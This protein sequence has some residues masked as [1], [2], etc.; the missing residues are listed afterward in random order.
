MHLIS[1]Q[2]SERA[3][4]DSGKIIS[5][6]GRTHVAWQDVTRQGYFNRVRT[7]DHATG[8]WSDPITLDRGVDNHARAVLCIDQD[9][10]LHAILGG[11]G[12]PVRWCHAL[13]YN[14]VS[15][16]SEPQPLGLGTYPVF[17]CGPDGTLYLTLRGNGQQRQD[18]GVDLYRRPPGGEWSCQRLVTL[19]EEYGQVYAAYHMQ[20]DAGPDG[21]LHAIIDF[22]EGED[23]H[24]RG[25]H[26]AT[27]YC[28]SN[29]GG[30]TWTRADGTP[31]TLPAR[32]EDLDILAQ[33]TR[34][35]HE[36]LPQ[37]DI[38][39]GGLI[40]DTTGQPFA[41]YID[42]DHGPGHCLLVTL[43]GSTLRQTPLQD[44]WECLYPDMRA[45]ECNLVRRQDDALCLLVTLAPFDNEWLDGKPTRA[46]RM[47]ERDDFRLIWLFSA[48]GGKTFEV[49]P[50]LEAGQSYN[51]PS[52]EKAVGPNAVPADRMPAV[53]YFDGSREYPGGGDYYAGDR[54]VD[55][56]LAGGVKANN[57]ILVGI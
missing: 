38:R 12:T 18:R 10:I 2:G 45:L 55:E 36:K 28:R 33:S 43:E 51:C 41:C 15:N 7:L 6:A 21:A 1:D 52:V 23:Q 9:G 29:D 27:C 4:N 32:P 42:H 5:F 54:S 57:V 24:S 34:S 56:I 49:Q 26:Q 35:R 8:Q 46:M 48:D 25:L 44:Y 37:P 17:L 50:F 22:Y 40:V 20:M 14:D 3:T 11:H 31:V 19:A 16:W 30:Q 47:R 53:L 13:A 39:Q